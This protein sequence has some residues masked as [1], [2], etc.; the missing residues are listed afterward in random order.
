M[1]EESAVHIMSIHRSKGLEFPVVFLC[2]TARRFNLQDT[3]EPVLVHPELG[4]GPK[5]V[6][7][8]LLV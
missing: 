5:I 2:D 3:F 8:D 6:D 1:D 7:N 4:L